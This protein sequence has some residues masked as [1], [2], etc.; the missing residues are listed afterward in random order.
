MNYRILVLIF[1]IRL[2]AVPSLF[3]AGDY[4]GGD[5]VLGGAGPKQITQVTVMITE[6]PTAAVPL[7]PAGNTGS[8]SVT[9]SP[10][11][12]VVLVDGVQRGVSP[13]TIPGIVPG[14][15]ALFIR[16]DG[17]ADYTAPIVVQAGQT[18]MYSATLS[19]ASTPLPALPAATRT[20]GFGAALG[21][22]A[23][24]A[25]LCVRKSFR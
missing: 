10:P 21:L 25:A 23:L 11:G 6:I 15:H 7:Q 16:M 1:L 13:V 3:A 20:P 17:Y 2:A 22:A 4:L 18:L 9:T 12:A 19:P 14:K 8:V 24:G 5:I